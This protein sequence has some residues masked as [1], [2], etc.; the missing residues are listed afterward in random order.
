MSARFNLQ[1]ILKFSLSP[2]I[3]SAFIIPLWAC[4]GKST[5]HLES[6]KFQQYYVV[7]EQ[8]YNKN[9][10]NCHQKS[11]EGLGL[12]YPPLSKSD[13]MDNNVE[14]VFCLMKYGVSGEISVNALHYNKPM[15]GIPSLTELE[16]AELS[17]YIYNTWGHHK[18]IIET[19]QVVQVINA[20]EQ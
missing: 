15:P 5:G 4:L 16:I 13:F 14:K 20:C 9:C 1:C 19:E 18:G 8:L 11:G 6:V 12:L 10:S 3:F 2:L 17:T 7:G